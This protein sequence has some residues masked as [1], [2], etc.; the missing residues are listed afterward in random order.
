MDYE[1][2]EDIVKTLNLT[3]LLNLNKHILDLIKYELIGKGVI[4]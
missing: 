4:K 1:T 2:V 3:E